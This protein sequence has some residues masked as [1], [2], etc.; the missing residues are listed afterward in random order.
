MPDIKEQKSTKTDTV[1][2]KTYTVMVHNDDF[3]TFEHVIDCLIRYCEH[4]DDQAT[5]CSYIIHYKGK[6]DVK[7][8]EKE[9]MMKIWNGLTSSNLTATLEV[10]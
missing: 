8:G 5:Q 3:N 9:K 4:D 1:L 2:N 10:I 6:C 7:R